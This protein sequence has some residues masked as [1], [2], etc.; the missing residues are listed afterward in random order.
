[1]RGLSTQ[2]L[3]DRDTQEVRLLGDPPALHLD[4]RVILLAGPGRLR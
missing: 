1:M 3:A 4:D 2:Q